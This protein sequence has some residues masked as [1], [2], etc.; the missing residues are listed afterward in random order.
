MSLEYTIHKAKNGFSE[1]IFLQLP[2]IVCDFYPVQGSRS[3]GTIEKAGGRRAGTEIEKE[4][5]HFH[6]R[7]TARRPPAFLIVPTDRETGTRF[8]ILDAV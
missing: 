1:L 5:S 4:T 8:F 7:S 6:L 3:V 2:P